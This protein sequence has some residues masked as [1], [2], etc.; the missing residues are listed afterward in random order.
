MCGSSANVIGW[1]T[2]ALT[3][4][5]L[6]QFYKEHQSQRWHTMIFDGTCNLTLLVPR[7]ECKRLVPRG[8]YHLRDVFHDGTGQRTKGIPTGFY[9]STLP[10]DA[11]LQRTLETHV[12]TTLG[13]RVSKLCASSPKPTILEEPHTT[14]N[15]GE[16]SRPGQNQ[17]P[18]W[19]PA[20]SGSW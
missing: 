12:F 6:S 18:F 1:S 10:E 13:S 20:T 7:R 19:P 17:P 15:R 14:Q 5:N 8:I 2:E 4:V 16:G 9:V 11:R 3:P